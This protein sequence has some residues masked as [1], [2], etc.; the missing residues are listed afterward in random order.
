M[1]DPNAITVLIEDF[2]NAFDN[3]IDHY[4][5]EHKSTSQCLNSNYTVCFKDPD[6]YRRASMYAHDHHISLNS[7]VEE[8][9]GAY[10]DLKHA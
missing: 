4:K 10:L 5:A 9:V 2:L 6:L 7:F 3:H 1:N 8:S